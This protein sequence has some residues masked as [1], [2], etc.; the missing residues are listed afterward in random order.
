MRLWCNNPANIYI[1]CF[2]G[3]LNIG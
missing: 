1:T 3:K 2:I